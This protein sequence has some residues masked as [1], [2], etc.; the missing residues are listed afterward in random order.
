VNGDRRCPVVTTIAVVIVAGIAV[1]AAGCSADDAEARAKAEEFVAAT[2]AAGLAPR[3]TVEVAEALYGDDAAAVCD[4]FEGGLTSAEHLILLG[5]PSDRRHKTITE[6]SI[7]Y[8]GLLVETYCPEHVDHFLDE[9]H[10]LDPY[11]S[12][13]TGATGQENSS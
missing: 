6:H 11:E 12:D 2:R 3:L 5:N 13:A 7:R 1:V 10:D 4:I 9:I 8:A